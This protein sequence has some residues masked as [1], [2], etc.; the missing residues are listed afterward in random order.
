VVMRQLQG[1]QHPAKTSDGE[2]RHD[3]G[4]VNSIL[5]VMHAS[6]NPTESEKDALIFGL[7][8]SDVGPV[9]ERIDL[10]C[11]LTTPVSPEH[12]DFDAVLGQLRAAILVAFLPRVGDPATVQ[13]LRNIVGRAGSLAD[14]DPATLAAPGAGTALAQ[15]CAGRIPDD[16]LQVLACEFTETTRGHWRWAELFGTI[17]RH[18]LELDRWQRVVLESSLYFEPERRRW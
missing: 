1:H 7:T 14:A 4:A 3:F 9:G 16:L 8:P 6:D 12:R 2:L 15:L 5:G 13:R 11:A 17:R 10:L 18:G